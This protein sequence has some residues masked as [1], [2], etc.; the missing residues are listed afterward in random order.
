MSEHL[1][2]RGSLCFAPGM[3]VVE[4]HVHLGMA[5]DRLNHSG[6]FLFVHQEC[7][8]RVTPKVVEA[9]PLH[10]FAVTVVGHVVLDPDDTRSYRS[11]TNIV[12]D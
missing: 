11:Q 6:I 1:L 4:G 8:K 10:H 5:H 9:E 2:L 12:L 3:R 7:R